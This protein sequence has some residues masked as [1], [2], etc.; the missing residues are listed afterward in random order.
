MNMENEHS[1][2]ET[3]PLMPA[4][5]GKRI[6]AFAMDFILLV[7][8]IQ[9]LANFFPDFYPASV[10]QEFNQ[11]LLD[12]SL[13]PEEVRGDSQQLANFLAD[14]KLSP[15][16][17]EMLLAMLFWACLIPILYF[18]FGE[19]FFD[20]Q[21]LGKATVRIKTLSLDGISPISPYRLLGK[22]IIKGLC[23]LSLGTPFFLPGLL[24]FLLC[25]LN[26]ERR[27]LHDLIGGCITINT[28]AV[29]KLKIS[30]AS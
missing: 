26:R 15:E 17:Y 10:K 20:G 4:P 5:L 18:F 7:L 27:C 2:K 25:F 8:L 21:T 6:L 14:S 9:L 19:R 29:P 30:D 24:N 22:A 3:E 16:T 13:L 23:S 12:A 28:P 11:V 1:I